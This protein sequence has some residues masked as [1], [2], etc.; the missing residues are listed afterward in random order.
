[1][2]TYK[3]ASSSGNSGFLWASEVTGG[4]YHQGQ[5]IAVDSSGNSYVAGFFS[6]TITVANTPLSCLGENILI[7][8]YDQTGNPLWAKQ[9]GGSGNDEASAVATDPAGNVYVTGY[10]NSSP[11]SF[12]SIQISPTPYNYTFIEKLDTNGRIQ[13]VKGLGGYSYSVATDPGGNVYVAGYFSGTASF[14]STILTSSGGYDIF[15]TKLDTTGNVIWAKTAGGTSD[16][17]AYGIAVDSA[18]NSYITGT[19]SGGAG[20]GGSNVASAGA[21]VAKLD[22]NGDF[23]WAK[24][25]AA[26]A[27]RSVGVD[28][29]GNS[30]MIG[31]FQGTASFGEAT[32]TSSGNRDIVLQKFDP[33]GNVLWARQAG[34]AADDFGFGIAVASSGNSYI[35]GRIEGPASFGPTTLTCAGSSEVFVANYDSSGNLGWAIQAN[36]TGFADGTA[37][38]TDGAGNCFITGQFGGTIDFGGSTFTGTENLFVSKIGISKVTPPVFSPAAG[39][40]PNSVQVTITSQAGATIYYTTDGS[41]PTTGSQEYTAPITLNASA[42]VSAIGAESGYNSSAVSTASYTVTTNP[43]QPG[44]TWA[45]PAS[46]TYGTPLGSSQL[47]AIANVPGT[48]TYFPSSGAVLHSGPQTLSATF[49]PTDPVHYS[50][51]STSVTI[52]VTPA[53][54]TVT[55]NS[56]TRAYG[57]ANPTFSAMITGLVNGDT[58]AVVGGVASL[59]TTATTGS[60]VGIYTITAAVGTLSAANYTFGNFANGLL[61]VTPFALTVTANST[62]RQYGAPNPNFSAAISGFLNGDTISVVGGAASVTSLATV[63]SQVGTYPIVAT[64]G[65][66]SAANYTFGNFVN[67]SLTVSPSTLTVTANNASRAYGAT[68]PVFTGTLFGLQNQDNIMASFT[69]AANATSP[70]GNYPI[71]PIFFDP[72]LALGNYNVVTNA[73]TLTVF[74]AESVTITFPTTNAVYVS[75]SNSVSL[76]GTVTD[77]LGV[78]EVTWVNNL[79]GGGLA[80]GT[81]SWSIP[82][83]PLAAGANLIKVTAF[84]LAGNNASATI[85]VS[86]T[87]IGFTNPQI[88]GGALTTTLTGLPNGGT[89]VLESSADLMN[90]T[91]IQ[92][93]VVNGTSLPVN[94]PLGPSPGQQF[95][96]AVVQ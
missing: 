40:Y 18:G 23:L 48:W 68:N 87:Q 90:W 85:T 83:V 16:D 46:I 33:S 70:A 26:Q 3:A 91:P 71:V 57:S 27:G 53:S 10:V 17:W 19:T 69:C 9:A 74:Q 95:L 35:T 37:I 79:G 60:T 81:N 7:I 15:I 1:M 6:G 22:S 84:D 31:F 13:W 64:A 63:V 86:Y 47:D 5:G 94:L 66:L 34:G 76:S 51:A 72:S 54:L 65:T 21:F 4:N 36:G 20:F 80:L 61:T 29:S 58:A 12:D 96:R 11:A 75:P 44:L 25:S 73:G 93:N 59:T 45:Q 28:P 77:N 8:K 30:Y 41:T 32:F 43:M 2:G 62:S 50:S 52:N 78:V 38:A 39:V 56:A 55:A 92:T 42:T 89:V 49:T 82:F 24:P 88:S 14:G 67:G